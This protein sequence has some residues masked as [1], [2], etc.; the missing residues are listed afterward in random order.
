MYL[1]T[2][3]G[4]FLWS[5]V[6]KFKGPLSVFLL[7]F[8]TW[9]LNE[10]AFP[11]FL[12]LIVDTAVN[13]AQSKSD[14]SQAWSHFLW[15]VGTLFA[16]WLI[17][18]SC[19]RIY[20]YVYI[21]FKPNFMAA[22]RMDVF[23]YVKEHS[24]RYFIDNLAG[25]LG[26]KI[27]DI[28]QS[29]MNLVDQF[30][31][32]FI[33][34]LV[35]F[36]FS[37]AIVTTVDILFASLML[38][39][40]TIHMGVT[41]YYLKPLINLIS[42]HYESQAKLTGE[43]I[44]I[45][46]NILSVRLFARTAFETMRLQSIYQSDEM[47][48]SAKVN[49]LHLKVNFIR[50]MNGNVFMFSVIY[51]LIQK[52]IKGEVTPGDISLVAMSC[53][54]IMGHL[55]HL[56]HNLVHMMQDYGTIQSALEIIDEP[57]GVVDQAQA[58]VL[59]VQKGEIVF[60][61]VTFGYKADQILFDQLSLRIKPG[62]KVGLVGFSGSGKTTLVNLIL[63]AFDLKSGQIQIDGQDVAAVT[64]DSLRQ[65]IALI[66]QDPSLF[67]RSIG[68]NIRYG[69]IDA[70]D[71]ALVNAAQKAHCHEFI[72]LMKDG[73]GTIVGERGLQLS[74]GQRQRLGIARA[75]LKNAPILI[76]DEAT[77]ALDSITEGYIQ[78][79]LHQ[80]M[81]GK[82]VLVVAHRLSTLASMD[83][84]LVFDKGVLKEDGTQA[85]LIANKGHFWR[86]WTHQQ[87]GFLPD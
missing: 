23:N 10:A 42:T 71:E 83:R 20:D 6:K 87:E 29:A 25:S 21:K 55:W 16:L 85:E 46:N 70:S 68:D 12:K 28:P 27:K 26:T 43:T 62:Q 7:C 72:T 34:L 54:T 11:Y 56:T 86:M 32:N 22:I 19:M 31:W 63:R 73:Y 45:F 4:A 74:G 78:E 17:M 53:F 44:D 47:G 69:N 3:P 48:K 41:L 24:L 50:G 30:L 18:D 64:Q 38:I 8:L 58:K 1:P 9:S 51:F 36:F 59:K 52:W 77:S 40:F 13:L 5:Y 33:G 39:F 2:T 49:R 76:L 60:D 15:P 80:L 84:I 79:S 67:H 75:F 14:L 37:V 66:P 57:H 81:E 35:G 65:E 82:T 61:K